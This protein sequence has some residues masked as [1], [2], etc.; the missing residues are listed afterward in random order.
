M[1]IQNENLKKT[2]MINT[3]HVI[4][5][6]ISLPLSMFLWLI[7]SAGVHQNSNF[8]LLWLRTT[9]VSWLICIYIPAA[10]AARYHQLRLLNFSGAVSSSILGFIHILTSTCFFFSFFMYLFIAAISITY[11]AENK[12]RYKAIG[13]KA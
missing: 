1:D 8:D 12:C 11:R 6:M 10:A 13:G 3:V 2:D 5:F 9:P 7:S 4:L